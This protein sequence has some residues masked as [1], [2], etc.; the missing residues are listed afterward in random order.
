MSERAELAAS[1]RRY[2]Q[3][4]HQYMLACLY[5]DPDGYVA[6]ASNERAALDLAARIERDLWAAKTAK[7]VTTANR[8]GLL[9]VDLK[10]ESCE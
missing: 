7:P 3:V 5:H 1:L 9:G 8:D 2:A 6:H 4:E 10:L